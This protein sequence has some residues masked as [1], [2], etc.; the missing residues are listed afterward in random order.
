M[1]KGIVR[2]VKVFG[3]GQ[4]SIVGEEI[5]KIMHTKPRG[6]NSKEIKI[7]LGKDSDISE[8]INKNPTY[9]YNVLSNL[10]KKG[11][12]EKEGKIYR[13]APNK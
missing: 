5:I 11:E 8:A 3:S 4:R 7:E 12:I 10:M 13:L 9:L 1:A 2:D 6:V